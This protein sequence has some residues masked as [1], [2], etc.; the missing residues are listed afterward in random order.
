MCRESART[1]EEL[2]A[3][4]ALVHLHLL[5]RLARRARLHQHAHR[6]V[7]LGLG[8]V[9]IR[10]GGRVGGR[11]TVGVGGGGGVGATFR[12][13]LILANAFGHVTLRRAAATGGGG[14]ID[15]TRTGTVYSRLG[16]GFFCVV[17]VELGI[18]VDA[19][20]HVEVDVEV[21]VEIERAV[22]SGAS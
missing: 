6:V 21:E 2:F 14:R 18:C 1:R 19:D 11:V 15:W 8:L 9:R 17:G 20:V 16:V 10:V 3:H 7:R 5:R 22:V 13:A 4:P 12:F